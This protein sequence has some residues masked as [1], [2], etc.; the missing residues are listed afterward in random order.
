M[1]CDLDW[2]TDE[3][4]VVSDDAVEEMVGRWQ[5]VQGDGGGGKRGCTQVLG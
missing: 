2:V 5:P 3:D 1:D 4:M